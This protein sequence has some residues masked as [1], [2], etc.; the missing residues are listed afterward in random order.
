LPFRTA[1]DHLDTRLPA[2]PASGNH[3]RDD[4]NVSTDLVHLVPPSAAP[5]QRIAS[6]L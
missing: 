1:E 3:T 4:L 6:N 2:P 5:E